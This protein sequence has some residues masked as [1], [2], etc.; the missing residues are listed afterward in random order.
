MDR[1]HKYREMAARGK[2]QMLYNYMC[3]LET[4]GWRTTLRELESIIGFELSASARLHRFWC[5]NQGSG[6]GHS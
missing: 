4:W 5:A 6:S 2:Y 3:R 1:D